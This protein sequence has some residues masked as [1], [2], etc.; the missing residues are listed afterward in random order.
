MTKRIHTD[1][2]HF[3]QLLSGKKNINGVIYNKKKNITM[4][5]FLTLCFRYNFY[6]KP[7]HTPL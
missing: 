7:T 4:T 5:T 2:K 3:Q 1:L 6:F